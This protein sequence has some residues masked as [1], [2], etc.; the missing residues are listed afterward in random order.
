MNIEIKQSILL[1]NLNYVIKGISTKN[2]IPILNCIKFELTNEG[3]YMT[4]TDNES[5]IRTFIPADL[6]E[7][8]K[9]LGEIV[10]S[11]RYIYEIIRK[12]PN[13]IVKIEE[14]IDNKINISTSNS[15]FDLNCNNVNEFPNLDLSDSKTPFHLTRS[16]FKTMIKQTSFAASTQENRP[17]FTGINFK[18][19]KNKLECTSTDSYRL[20]KKE[21]VIEE[22]LKEDIN[23]I[24]PTKNLVELERMINDSESPIFI[25]IFN[26]KVIFKFDNIIMMS[27]LIN[28]TYPD[29]NKLIPTDFKLIL[30]MNLSDFYQA[31]DRASLLT[32]EFDKNTIKLNYENNVII[33]SSNIPEIGHVEEKIYVESNNSETI[34]LAFSSK[35][36][37]DA[38]KSFECEKIN[39]KFNG[40]EKPIILTDNEN[41]D[42][43]QL[44]LPVKTY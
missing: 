27:R 20:A 24:V 8:I 11:G 26:N 23:I 13:E 32:S 33:V 15:S 41:D 6:I 4:S 44:I 29:T 14:F 25:H 21:I 31:I 39:I 1:E 17:E 2:I 38:L 18:I 35:Y 37:L 10:I 5:A 16:E 12:L 19:N 3:L 9:C 36:M 30:T 28:G 22:N 42:V 40:E 34:K 7:N 43:T